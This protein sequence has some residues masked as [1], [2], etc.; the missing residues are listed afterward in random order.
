MAITQNPVIGRSKQSFANVTMTTWK[1]RNVLKSKTF[2]YNDAK[3]PAQ[4]DNRAR[5]KLLS[6]AAAAYRGAILV[7]LRKLATNVTEYN[8]F[9]SK[10]LN[11][12]LS[13]TT[14]R[15]EINTLLPTSV[16]VSKG[17]VPPLT[18]FNCQDL[19]PG[20]GQITCVWDVNPNVNP[21]AQIMVLVA[22]MPRE[23]LSGEEYAEDVDFAFNLLSYGT[24]T[25]V[26]N[27]TIAAQ[28]DAVI[29]FVID[30]D[31][32]DVSDNVSTVLTA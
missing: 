20:S 2:S 15:N 11:Y 19:S 30:S 6:W 16:V 25:G 29:A 4:Q 1:G 23:I 26:A 31:T 24:G 21:N 10:S 7:G 28:G 3:T 12:Y 22:K 13:S 5:L 14:D 9:V 32:S 8:L 17:S 27:T 18:N